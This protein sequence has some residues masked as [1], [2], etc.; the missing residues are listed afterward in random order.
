[1]PIE[2]KK[3]DEKTYELYNTDRSG[4]PPPTAI[5]QAAQ[6]AYDEIRSGDVAKQM[7]EEEQLRARHR[8]EPSEE[9]PGF[10]SVA[11]L[12]AGCES[13][14]TRAEERLERAVP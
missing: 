3:L 12:L 2:K 1:M 8:V 13:S 6:D 4:V 10:G 14:S 9:T 11:G 7:F 5:T